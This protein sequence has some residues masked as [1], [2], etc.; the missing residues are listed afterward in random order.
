MERRLY[1]IVG[2][3]PEGRKESRESQD[4]RKSRCAL[5][6]SVYTLR[7]GTIQIALVPSPSSPYHIH[8]L[9]SSQLPSFPF[10]SVFFLFFLPLLP[11]VY[12]TLFFPFFLSSFS[13]SV[14]FFSPPFFLCFSCLLS[15]S[16]ERPSSFLCLCAYL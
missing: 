3:F 2:L 6:Q 12:I 5:G 14:L 4:T 16:L 11:T 15:T 7:L 1:S 8:T 10:F 13:S 9:C